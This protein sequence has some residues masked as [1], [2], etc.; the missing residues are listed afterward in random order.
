MQIPAS[1]IADVTAGALIGLFRSAYLAGGSPKGPM[2][3]HLKTDSGDH[4]F[5]L[6]PHASKICAD[7]LLEFPAVELD[8]P[9]SLKKFTVVMP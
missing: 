8:P 6:C 9:A 2:V 3:Y 5:Y 7:I 1:S 4:V